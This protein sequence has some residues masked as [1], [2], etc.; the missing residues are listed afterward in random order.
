MQFSMFTQSINKRHHCAWAT[1][2]TALAFTGCT[3]FATAGA[4]GALAA[5]LAPALVMGQKGALSI[6]QTMKTSLTRSD[7]VQSSQRMAGKGE[8]SRCETA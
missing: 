5:A 8:P 3:A 6:T 1:A 7:M 2:L 4:A